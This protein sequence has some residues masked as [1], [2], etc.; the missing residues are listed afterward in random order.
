[1]SYGTGGRRIPT[2]YENNQQWLI[3]Q[4]RRLHNIGEKCGNVCPEI[5]N[6][7]NAWTPLKL[8][9]LMHYVDVY[10]KIMKKDRFRTKVF[11]DVFS[12]SGLNRISYNLSRQL[13]ETTHH[14]WFPSSSIIAANWVTSDG[15]FNNIIAIDNNEQYLDSL[16]LRMSSI[17]PS[18]TFTKVPGNAEVELPKIVDE[19][20]NE[21]SHY[22]AFVDYG[23]LRSVRLDILETLLKQ[24]GDMFVT[25]LDKGIIRLFGQAQSEPDIQAMLKN[26]FG[27]DVYFN[28]LDKQ[29][30]G[31]LVTDDIVKAFCSWFR[32]YK[33]EVRWIPIRSGNSS[34]QYLLFFAVAKTK[35]GTS[36]IR[37]I[38]DLKKRMVDLSGKDV[39]KCLPIVCGNQKTLDKID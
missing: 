23:D 12:G 7:F 17:F 19:I 14:C 8:I 11:L 30:S 29:V 37:V 15:K 2:R 39:S 4:L 9:C 33:E 27:S 6:E 10:S 22:L 13:K 26:A 18:Q 24:R 20:I 31:Q 3:E 28:L 32:K 5:F 34:Y 38:D 25:V 21:R 16:Q 1:M 36:F 35:G